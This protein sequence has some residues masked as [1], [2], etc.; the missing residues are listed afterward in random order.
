MPKFYVMIGLPGSGKTY[1]ASKLAEAEICT[2]LSSDDIR[3]ELF[4]DASIQ[5]DAQKVFDLMFE[6]SINL[7]KKNVNVIY[8]ATNISSKRRIDLLKRISSKVSC[9]KIAVFVATPFLQCIER[10]D[11]RERKVLYNVIKRMYMNFNVPCKQE[12][13]DEIKVVYP[14]HI[15]FIPSYDIVRSMENLTH[16][17]P[18]H[19]TT[20]GYHM[21]DAYQFL[22]Y[23]HTYAALS[24]EVLRSAVLM[25]DIGKKFTKTFTNAKGEPTKE[26]HYY[27][28]NNVG[29]YDVFFTTIDE[30]S[31]IDTALLIQYH[32]NYYTSWKQSE[33]SKQRDAKFLGKDLFEKLE[34]L[35]E[36]DLKAH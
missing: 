1:E 31:K 13:F 22:L 27:N 10:N 34:I 33:K 4:G 19:T 11:L 6:R 8:D 16:D 30:Q 5:S 23:R 12:G 25:H 18:H 21:K 14:E 7:L 32:M 24:S 17:N 35:H 29:A 15:D 28:H 3:E 36:C 9:E 20:V 2:I 26:A